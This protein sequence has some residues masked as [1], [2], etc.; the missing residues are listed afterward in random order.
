MTLRAVGCVLLTLI[1]ASASVA[2]DIRR[3]EAVGSVPIVKGKR[4]RVGPKEAAIDAALREAVYRVARD[5][6]IDQAEGP[7]VY[8]NAPAAGVADDPELAAL[9]PALG[10]DMVRYTRSFRILEDRGEGP[11]LFG[12]APGAKTEY[13][14]IV[15]VQVDADRVEKRLA[16]RGLITRSD[17]PGAVRVVK[18][19]VTGL[20]EYGAYQ[21]LEGVLV[22][23]LGAKSVTPLELER[24][25][26]L[27]AVQTALEP[28][29]LLHQL[30]AVTPENL[31]IAPLA[32]EA[33]A[34]RLSVYWTPPEP[35]AVAS[36]GGRPATR[37]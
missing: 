32:A 19:E 3:I 28:A 6:L 27:L 4:S 10:D 33:G 37:R 36:P 7:I 14:V 34:V 8:D 9:R 13:V 25:R 15:Q 26:S 21:A 31:D 22:E 18:L 11:A 29:E 16:E 17:A 23:R 12:D 2:A 35:E 20:S 30:L 1:F 5:F 24:G